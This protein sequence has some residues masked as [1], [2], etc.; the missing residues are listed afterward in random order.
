MSGRGAARPR[1]HY[2]HEHAT[3]VDCRRTSPAAARRTGRSSHALGAPRLAPFGSRA[4]RLGL[5]AR[6]H[7]RRRR[8]S[9]PWTRSAGPVLVVTRN[10]VFAGK[11]GHA[12]GTDQIVSD[13]AEEE[14]HSAGQYGHLKRAEREPRASFVTEPRARTWPHGRSIGGLPGV[15]S[16]FEIGQVNVE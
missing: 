2:A 16:S 13:C 3:G 15:A 6:Y 14:E 4:S 8:A 10:G 7:Y 5:G 11:L 1:E 9:R 12:A